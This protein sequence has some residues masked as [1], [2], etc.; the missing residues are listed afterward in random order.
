MRPH[1]HVSPLALW[2]KHTLTFYW[3]KYSG[4][5]FLNFSKWRKTDCLRFERYKVHS[6]RANLVSLKMKAFLFR[7]FHSSCCRLDQRPIN[8]DIDKLIQSPLCALVSACLVISLNAPIGCQLCFGFEEKLIKM[9]WC[10]WVYLCFCFKSRKRTGP[11][12]LNVVIK[13]GY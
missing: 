9:W 4:N 13:Y 7:P 6:D 3:E 2:K 8:W 11:I 12:G 1:K 5:I 10:L